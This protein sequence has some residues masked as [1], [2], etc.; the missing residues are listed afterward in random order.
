MKYM[1]LCII[2]YSF[3]SAT[4]CTI[5]PA[6][7]SEKSTYNATY[8]A[9]SAL[10]DYG[11]D[12]LLS[13]KPLIYSFWLGE[14]EK[15]ASFVIDLGCRTTVT[16]VHLRNGG[17]SWQWLVLP[18][19]SNDR[20]NYF[21]CKPTPLFFRGS[22]NFAVEIGDTAQG[23]WTKIAEGQLS[24]PDKDP[25]LKKISLEKPATGRFVQYRCINGY[26]GYC[27]LQ[28]IGLFHSSSEAATTVTTAPTTA[29]A[30]TTPTTSSTTTNST[31]SG[32]FYEA[33]AVYIC[34]IIWI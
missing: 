12:V 10:I 15:P 2:N 28:Y 17:I 30:T 21:C 31:S 18:S 11:D 14:Y 9:G 5:S 6:V 3:A 29:T 24:N 32:L 25:P 19:F 22:K 16:E 8:P 33:F 20:S 27:G 26:D 7:V 13:I 4:D 34:H 1:M 23:P